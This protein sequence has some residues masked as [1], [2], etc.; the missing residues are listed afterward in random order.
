[1]P[2]HRLDL[3]LEDPRPRLAVVF[4]EAA[5]KNRLPLGIAV[6]FNFREEE[7]GRVEKKT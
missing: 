6:I 1:M 3:Q 7:A 5:A 2:R 4:S